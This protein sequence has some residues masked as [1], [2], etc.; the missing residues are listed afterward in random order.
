M[1]MTII[2]KNAGEDQRREHPEMEVSWY[3][4]CGKVRRFL[5]KTLKTGLPQD[6]TITILGLYPRNLNYFVK[7]KKKKG[8]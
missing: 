2:R 7:K 8:S 5:K 4:R 3:S 1:G 6:P